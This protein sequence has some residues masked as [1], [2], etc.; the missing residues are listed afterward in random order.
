MA[1]RLYYGAFSMTVINCLVLD[2]S[3]LGARVETPIMMQVPDLFKIQIGDE[4]IRY[5]RRCWS[6]GNAIG[7]EFIAPFS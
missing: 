4:D 5:A 2:R 3:T 6:R 7:L 1:G